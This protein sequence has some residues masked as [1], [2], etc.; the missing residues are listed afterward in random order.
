M[1][2]K[3][4]FLSFLISI[5]ISKKL[6]NQI[7]NNNKIYLSQSV[8]PKV[9]VKCFY[10]S[11]LSN[12]Y[13][14]IDLKYPILGKDDYKVEI[15]DT[16]IY[17][18]FC[19]N[20]KNNNCNDS[21]I[22][23][24]ISK[25]NDSCNIEAGIIDEGNEWKEMI[26]NVTESNLNEAG[27]IIKLNSGDK[28][29]DKNRKMTFKLHCDNNKD[30]YKDENKKFKIKKIN[31]NSSNCENEIIFESYY[32][33]PLLDFYLIWT[34]IKEMRLVTTI[35]FVVIGI[36]LL[37]FGLKF[38]K[39]NIFILTFITSII[40]LF[41]LILQYFIPSGGNRQIFF[42]LTLVM[43]VILGIFIAY[44]FADNLKTLLSLIL[45]F[46]GG[47]ILGYLIYCIFLSKINWNTNILYLISLIVSMIIVFFLTYC[48]LVHIM[49]IV[50]SI[51]GGYLCMR[52][53]SFWFEYYPEESRIIDLIVN[54]END[55]LNE[56]MTVSFL[57]YMIFL[58]VLIAGGMV[59]QYKMF[60]HEL[61]I[62]NKKE[63]TGDDALNF[64]NDSNKG[65]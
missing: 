1:L 14:L 27:V 26:E 19:G 50:T 37:F 20:V 30:N 40:I 60:S 9:K 11:G 6:F 46:L 57:I 5:I 25:T 7:D 17:F 39:I 41:I 15:N 43:S 63:K 18:N 58:V 10:F 8:I 38:Q 47:Y 53:S 22:G 36:F 16:T 55:K 48:L 13:N 35:I 23:Q 54:G 45:G 59:F 21:K 28:C 64:L 56:I 33:C 24:V 12:V 32:A 2:E 65:K 49:V 4:F 34:K 44:I 42:W 52:A 29:E 3:I 31:Y 62:E 61:M 51:I